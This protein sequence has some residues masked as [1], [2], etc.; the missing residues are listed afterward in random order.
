M[1]GGAQSAMGCTVEDTC[2]C[3][4]HTQTQMCARTH[5]CTQWH[6]H[7]ACTHI[8]KAGACS[9]EQGDG[10]RSDPVFFNI[11]PGS[12]PCTSV[13]FTSLHRSPSLFPRSKR[14]PPWPALI[15]Y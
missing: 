13:A 10:E 7:N 8:H 14:P 6:M 15:R 5:T 11:R 2:S 9:P 1:S 12:P 3:A 4:A